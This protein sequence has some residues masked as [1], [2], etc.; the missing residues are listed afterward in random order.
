MLSTVMSIVFLNGHYTARERAVI[1]VDDRGF[2]FGDGIYEGVRAIEGR[3]F[4]WPAHAARMRNGLA[5][6]RIPF[7]GVDG[8]AAVCERLLAENDLRR[9]EAFL[10]IAVSRGAAPR[11][12]GFPTVPTT[13]TVFVSATP[14]VPA[15]EL[16][17]RGVAAITHDDLRWG[18]CDLKTLNLLGS[19]FARQAAVEAGA[20][21][22]ILYRGGVV[23][24][25]AATTVFV[26]VDG[27]LR[28][29]PL[30]THILPGV[31]RD[32]VISCATSGLEVPIREVA[33]TRGE[34]ARADEI[35]L[36]GTTNDLTPVTTLDG[37]PVGRGVPG[38]IGDRLRQLLDARLYAT[39]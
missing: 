8:L 24:E 36:V 19:V 29:H 37:A 1:S 3:L 11:T 15:R 17:T 18:R 2:T 21:E 6:L 4:S 30:S 35:L 25:G 31:T 33:V 12:H 20:Y 28:T 26:V 27:A 22:A 23:T 13:P 14:F 10:Y 16:R 7:D 38:P 32:V 9:G 5:G 34:L 39:V